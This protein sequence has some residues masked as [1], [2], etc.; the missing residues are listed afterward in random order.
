MDAGFHLLKVGIE[1]VSR[2]RFPFFVESRLIYAS[3]AC[4]VPEAFAPCPGSFR[5]HSVSGAFLS[6]SGTGPFGNALCAS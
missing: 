6:A 3:Y 1:E 2:C 5:S 4:T